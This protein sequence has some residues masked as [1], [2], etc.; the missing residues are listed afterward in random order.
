MGGEEVEQVVLPVADGAYR[1]TSAYG[2]RTYPIYGT[3][4][5]V[6]LAARLGTPLRAVASGVVTYAGGPRDGRTGS[7]I[8]VR[9]EIAGQTVEFWYGHMFADGLFV[10]EGQEVAAGDVIGEVGN[11]GR[12]TGPH[13]HFEVHPFAGEATTDPMA[14]LATNDARSASASC[15]P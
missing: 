12:S 1:L 4:E 5:G 8:I 15:E 6:D 2:F 3:H 14:W 7:I 13:V 11:A 9:S 10:S